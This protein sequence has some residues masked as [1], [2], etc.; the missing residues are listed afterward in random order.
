MIYLLLAICFGC[1]VV[2]ATAISMWLTSGHSKTRKGLPIAL[3][4]LLALA[5]FVLLLAHYVSAV[6]LQGR[7]GLAEQARLNLFRATTVQGLDRDT[8][9]RLKDDIAQWIE[10]E[11][12]D[13]DQLLTH[14]HDQASAMGLSE[15]LEKLDNSEFVENSETY[16]IIRH[17]LSVS[18]AA[19]EGISYRIF[20]PLVQ[21]LL[22]DQI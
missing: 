6:N 3:G 4:S 8:E 9:Y 5:V 15:Y 10:D 14:V 16:C 21:A 2:A 12:P 20:A 11:A 19:R 13:C 7:E 17:N 22:P 18:Y 1:I